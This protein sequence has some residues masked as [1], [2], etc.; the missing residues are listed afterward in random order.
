MK[1]AKGITVKELIE[2][3]QTVPKSYKVQIQNSDNWLIYRATSLVNDGSE[4]KS[5]TIFSE[6]NEESVLI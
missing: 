5:V 3:L 4:F 1:R 2:F 6:E